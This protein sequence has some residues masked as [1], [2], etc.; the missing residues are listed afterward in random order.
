MK[1]MFLI[2]IY[3]RFFAMLLLLMSV[4]FD[5]VSYAKKGVI[6]HT[7]RQ[8]GWH[9]KAQY[10]LYVEGIECYNCLKSVCRI[11]HQAGGQNIAVNNYNAD[12]ENISFSFLFTQRT[13][14]QLLQQF[15]QKFAKEGF[16]FFSL[17][18]FFKG[19]IK[20][21]DATR[22]FLMENMCLPF[23]SNNKVPTNKTTV[24]AA[25][26]EFSRADGYRLLL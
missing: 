10:T 3:M 20:E 14:E 11:I 9:K 13:H 21:H 24:L 23:A 2:R 12:F 1:M 5:M 17:Q 25:T 16:E 19:V 15:A 8:R 22:E 6:K 26:L 7:G 4:H 18:G